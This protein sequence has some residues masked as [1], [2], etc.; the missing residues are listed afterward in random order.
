MSSTSTVDGD[1]DMSSSFTSTTTP[2]SPSPAP[3]STPVSR[4]SWLS[5]ATLFVIGTDTLLVAPL[6][7]TLSR[8]FNVPTGVSGWMVSAYALGY[9][10]FA[11]LISFGIYAWAGAFRS[12]QE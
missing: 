3:P 4:V 10:L 5:F 9:A 12:R 6:L 8:A 1:H 2:L 7:S 11:Y